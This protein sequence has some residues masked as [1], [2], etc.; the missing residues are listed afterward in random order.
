[1]SKSIKQLVTEAFDDEDAENA[2]KFMDI[3]LTSWRQVS[4][5]L[6][7]WVVIAFL[8]AAIF[9]LLINAKTI[10]SIS[11]GG[12]SF[13]NTSLLQIF[14]PALIAYLIYY[15]YQMVDTFVDHGRIYL[16]ILKKY[17]PK[18]YKSEL[19]LAVQP[20]LR[21]PWA[22]YNVGLPFESNQRPIHKFDE[23]INAIVST[24]A[25][26]II[27]PAFQFQAYYELVQKYGFRNIYVWISAIITAFFVVIFAIR[28]ITQWVDMNKHDPWA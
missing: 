20:Q 11:I 9:E 4:D 1:M 15:A 13:S 12:L 25:F 22:A 18:L 28:I 7:R 26:F 14:M 10:N 16:N 6:T 3:V 23:R 5:A 17:Q 24:A 21:G 19:M 2:Q 8:L 27:P